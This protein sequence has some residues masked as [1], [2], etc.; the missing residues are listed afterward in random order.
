MPMECQNMY[1]LTYFQ[2]GQ[3]GTT[4]TRNLMDL[5]LKGCSI[6]TLEDLLFNYY[7][8]ELN[9][10]WWWNN[11][12]TCSNCWSAWPE[13]KHIQQNVWYD[14]N[15]ILV[16]RRRQKELKKVFSSFN[17]EILRFVL[18][19]L[20]KPKSWNTYQHRLGEIRKKEWMNGRV[21][22]SER[23]KKERVNEIK[24]HIVKICSKK[25][26]FKLSCF[27]PE[28]ESVW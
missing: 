20:R 19:P 25:L 11:S 5:F 26:C 9:R 6:V 1:T 21:W 7:I 13:R 18:G 16:K 12:K 15:E 10:P 24:I 17:P 22:S 8:T 14:L 23:V 27:I 4:I 2:I 3:F 28:Q